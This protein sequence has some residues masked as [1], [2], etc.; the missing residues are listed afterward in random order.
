MPFSRRLSNNNN[1]K[2][3][4]K[5]PNNTETVSYIFFNPIPRSQQ[6]WMNILL[7]NGHILLC[8]LTNNYPFDKFYN[9]F[10][11]IY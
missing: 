6:V 1:K 11:N 2:R 10:I 5:V 8:E 4:E 3:V 9:F 7:I